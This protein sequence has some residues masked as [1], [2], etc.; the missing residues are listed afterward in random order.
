MAAKK[1]ILIAEDEK[2]MAKALAL[3]LSKAGYA[4]EN[5]YDGEEALVYLKNGKFDLVLLD[6]MM[7]KVDGFGVLEEK[8]KRGDK[9][10]VIVS[11]NLSQTEDQD[12]CKKLGAVDYFVKS[13][14]PITEVIVHVEKALKK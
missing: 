1:K 9:T 5:A 12:K 7:P 2:P 3:K 6:L 11:T 14:T 13:N 8:Q 4:V 10:P